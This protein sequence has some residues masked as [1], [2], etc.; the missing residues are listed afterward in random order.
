MKSLLNFKKSFFPN[1]L[2]AFFVCCIISLVAIYTYGLGNSENWKVP[3]SYGAGD[4]VWVLNMLDAVVQGDLQPFKPLIKSEFAAPFTA[5]YSDW[6]IGIIIEMLPAGWLVNLFG[7]AFGSNLYLIFCHATAGLSMFLCLRF[8]QCKTLWAIVFGIAFGLCPYLFTRNFSHLP[9]INIAYLIP[10]ICVFLRYLFTRDLEKINKLQL[11]FI[12]LLSFF[13]GTQWPYYSAPFIWGVFVAAIFWAIN[14]NWK[15]SLQRYGICLA[16]F[17]GG[18]VLAFGPTILHSMREG[19]NFEAVKRFYGQMQ[20]SALRPIEMFLPGSHSGVPG[21]KQLSAFY[22]NQCL[23][24]QNFETSGSMQAYLGIVGCLGFLLLFGITAYYVLSRQQFKISGWF[25]FALFLIAFSVVGGLNG[26][27]GLA[28]F[29]F[30]KS[31]NRYSIYITAIC[32]IYFAM[33]L[34]SNSI[35]FKKWISWV[36][37]A[38]LFLLVTAEPLFAKKKFSGLYTAGLSLYESDRQFGMSLEKHLPAGAMVFNFPVIQLPERGTYAIFRPSFFTDNIRYSFG[39]IVGRARDTWQ[40]EIEKLPLNLAVENLK[41]YGFSGILIY[42]GKD[43][44]EEQKIAAN[45]AA[46]F[47]KQNQFSRIISPAGD[48]EFFAFNPNPKPVF[49]PVRPMYVNNWWSTQIQPAGFTNDSGG[50]ESGWRWT[51]HASAIVEVFN[52]QPDAK[53]LILRGRVLGISEC[54]VEIFVKQKM[55]FSGKISPGAPVEFSTESIEVAGHKAVRFEFKSDRKPF[56]QEGKKFCFAVSDLEARWE[57][58]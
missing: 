22:E 56:V 36:I 6:P 48:F 51:T 4:G 23:F 3:P 47:F 12:Y 31:S 21:L 15:A 38:L 32:L 16:S 54:E 41:K 28:K 19:K 42:N 53:R 7:L 8:M 50:E 5:D 44:S 13:I 11:F 46:D 37:A 20:K 58:E 2:G 24:R 17:I 52:K 45:Q 30:L 39:S 55:V 9:L 27:L 43:L 33:F 14:G 10:I 18:F 34:S 35:I 57:K 29:Y 49:P 40:L 26:F 25:W 1:V